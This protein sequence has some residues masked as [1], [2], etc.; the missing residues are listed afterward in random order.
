M[1]VKLL[2]HLTSFGVGAAVV[3]PSSSMYNG[4][5]NLIAATLPG[6]NPGDTSEILRLLAGLLIGVLS[7]FIYGFIDKKFKDKKQAKNEEV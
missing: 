7:K 3:D 2:G 5:H 1:S 4:V 6:M